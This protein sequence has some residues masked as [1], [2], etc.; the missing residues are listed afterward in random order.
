M[1]L[2]ILLIVFTIIFPIGGYFAGKHDNDLFEGIFG[3]LSGFAVV[4]T[5][6]SICLTASRTSDGRYFVEQKAYHDEL[7][8][9]V[10]TYSDPFVVNKVIE[11]VQ[12]DNKRI[13]EHRDNVNSSWIGCY[14][15]KTIAECELTE[16]PELKVKF[17]QEDSE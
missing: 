14:Y 4:G 7:L 11:D 9:H 1:T 13:V 2:F 5:I 12:K 16:I 3:V 10:E 6:V 8:R 17:I 15:S